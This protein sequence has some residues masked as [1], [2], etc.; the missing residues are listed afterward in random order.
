MP[1]IKRGDRVA[2][3]EEGR[4]YYGWVVDVNPHEKGRVRVKWHPQYA[5][6]RDAGGLTKIRRN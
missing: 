3:E 2:I 6:W 5:E 1:T 4:T